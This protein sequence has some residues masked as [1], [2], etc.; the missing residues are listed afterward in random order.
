M[1]QR[2]YETFPLIVYLTRLALTSLLVLRLH[3]HLA[4]FSDRKSGF[5]MNGNT[6]DFRSIGK[7]PVV[8]SN[9]DTSNSKLVVL[10]LYSRIGDL[11]TGFPKTGPESVFPFRL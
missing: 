2:R 7:L 1:H 11:K 6:F 4:N 3:S 5:Q 10:N 9:G 8:L